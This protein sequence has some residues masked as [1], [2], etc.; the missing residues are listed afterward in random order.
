MNEKEK[1]KTAI[2]Q[3]R[4]LGYASRI[5]LSP[6]DIEK[7]FNNASKTGKGVFVIGHELDETYNPD[8]EL[9]RRIYLHWIGDP[10][11]ILAALH[12][13]GLNV[14][15]NGRMGWAIEVRPEWEE[16]PDMDF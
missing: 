16:V 12:E 8:G 5:N 11:E 1:I 4:K 9:Q 2:T 10:E 13:Q 15:W 14:Y 7:F 6:T 3:I